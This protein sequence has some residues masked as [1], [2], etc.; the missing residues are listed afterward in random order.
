M[1][2]N[3]KQ[4]TLTVVTLLLI[5]LSPFVAKAQVKRVTESDKT[6]I[7]GSILRPENFKHSEAWKDNA[8]NTVYLLAGNI[9]STYLPRIAGVRFVLV[10]P[11]DLE[12]MKKTG[13]E[14][15]DFSG[16]EITKIF[17]RVIFRRTYMNAYAK[18][19]SRSEVEYTCRKVAGRW[20]VEIHLISEIDD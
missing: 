1:K 4:Q 20:K 13:V 15:Y 12:E 16:F 9:S 10:K 3:G 8:E 5:S 7:I 11:E 17:V 14:Y 18:A 6:Q 2:L 19:S